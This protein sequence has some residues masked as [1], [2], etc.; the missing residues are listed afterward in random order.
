VYLC[1][2]QFAG[3]NVLVSRHSRTSKAQECLTQV[4]LH[5]RQ[6]LAWCLLLNSAGNLYDCRSLMARGTCCRVFTLLAPCQ[7]ADLFGGRQP[8]KQPIICI[9]KQPCSGACSFTCSLDCICRQLSSIEDASS[10]AVQQILQCSLSWK[11]QATFSLKKD[12]RSRH[13]EL[14][15]IA[16]QLAEMFSHYLLESVMR[17]FEDCITDMM[18]AFWPVLSCLLLCF[19][20]LAQ[21]P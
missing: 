10:T 1:D 9:A 4:S 16:P 14:Q 21:R 17:C 19:L 7:H 5:K 18:G 2:W 8:Y 13:P 12:T 20:K 6:C 11:L 15:R 3:V